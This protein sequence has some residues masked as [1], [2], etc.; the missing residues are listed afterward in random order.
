LILL[1]NFAVTEFDPAC[2]LLFFGIITRSFP[3]SF[4]LC[5]F[6]RS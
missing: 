2:V 6:S 5:Y 4:F 1:I 3:S